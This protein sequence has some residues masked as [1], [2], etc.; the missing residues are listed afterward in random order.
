MTVTAATITLPKADIRF[1]ETSG[2]EMPIVLL[3]GSSASKAAFARQLQGRWAQS[4]PVRRYEGEA[5][6][7]LPA[8]VPPADDI[9]FE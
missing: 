8:D 1:V 4:R 6:R 9:P 7:G 5:V 2:K 3:H